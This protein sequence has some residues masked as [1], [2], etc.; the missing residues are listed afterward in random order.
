MSGSTS[1]KEAPTLTDRL[2]ADLRRCFDA[3]EDQI[4]RAHKCLLDLGRALES[5]KPALAQASCDK[6]VHELDRFQQSFAL[7]RFEVARS[8]RRRADAD[9]LG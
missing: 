3:A 2:P 4:I 6:I 7:L 5:E 1:S 9:V 8:A